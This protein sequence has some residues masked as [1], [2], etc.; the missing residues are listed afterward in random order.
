M[1]VSVRGDRT[2]LEDLKIHVAVLE[3][4]VK[5]MKDQS[6]EVSKIRIDLAVLSARFGLLDPNKISE[7]MINL[8]ISMREN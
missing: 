6:E 8:K 1:K 5:S 3:Q 2:D 7:D 4:V